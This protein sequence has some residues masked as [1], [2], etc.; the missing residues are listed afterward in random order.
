VIEEARDYI[1]RKYP[2]SDFYVAFYPR[3]SHPFGNILAQSCEAKGIKVLNYTNIDTYE[4]T[5]MREMVPGDGHPSPLAHYIFAKL[6]DR[7]LPK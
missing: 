6:L 3:D 5:N 7:D 4:L 2:G 1:L